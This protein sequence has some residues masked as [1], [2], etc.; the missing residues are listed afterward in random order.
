MNALSLA[1]VIQHCQQHQRIEATPRQWQVLHHL[2]DCRTEALGGQHYTCHHCQHQW[3]WY[4]S[5]R[6]RHCPQC[7]SNASEQWCEQQ[8]AQL[9]PVPYFHLVFTLPHELNN[10]I[11]R[12]GRLLY[13]LLFQSSWSSLS[14]LG[15]HKLK[16]QL[17]MTAILHTWGQQLTRHVHLHC[18]V[19]SGSLQHKHRW[20]S[21]QKGY[22]LPVK[23]LS[24]RFRGQMVS[25]IRAAWQLQQLPGI[26]KGD[27]D[28]T[29]N[30]VMQKPWVVYSKPA[31]H[32]RETLV[33][34]LAHY[35]HR[36]GLSNQR[37][38]RWDGEKITLRY[39]DYAKNHQSQLRLTPAELLRRFLLHV[40]PK[41]FMRIRHY[42]YLAN[43]IKA[44]SLE[45]IR[46]Q[47]ITSKPQASQHP[48]S[49]SQNQITASQLHCPHCQSAAVVMMQ[50][51]PL[52]Q[53][54]PARCAE[55]PQQINSS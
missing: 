28:T 16:G 50:H 12:Y 47:L 21:H 37:I 41:G 4:H 36:I 44:R 55:A 46:R 53:P 31:L 27:I 49:S 9:L 14:Q 33:H 17:G 25:R 39:L 5:C 20:H 22:L 3:H 43:A 11:G 19:P 38:T 18:L 45:C 6:D 30:R 8:K 2:L 7:Q 52:K 26:S 1:G 23:A 15:A 51:N 40:L 29:L 42:G 35:S 48:E 10:W 32:Y 34:Y 24:N 13:N 54:H